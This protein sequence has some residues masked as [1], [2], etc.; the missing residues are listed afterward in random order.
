MRR[1]WIDPVGVE[2]VAVEEE[3]RGDLSRMGDADKEVEEEEEEEDEGEE[4]S[5]DDTVRVGR[6]VGLNG[7]D[8]EEDEAAEANTCP[9]NVNGEGKR[10]A[11][12]ASGLRCE[13]FTKIR[14]REEMCA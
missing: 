1:R 8:L 4:M 6:V 10:S 2:G 5:A 14:V 12:Q 13:M 11:R 9:G 7:D 3:G